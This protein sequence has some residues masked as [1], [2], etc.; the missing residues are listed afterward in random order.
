[1][2]K[3]MRCDRFR[4]LANTVG[5]VALTVNRASCDVLAWEVSWKEP[6][7]GLFDSPPGTQDLQEFR[8]EHNITILLPLTLLDPDDHALAVDGGRGECDGLGDAQAGGIA[9]GQDC[10]MF[11]GSDATHPF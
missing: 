9:G 1:M 2:S 8:R 5:L 7:L 11:P 6:V 10:A 3:R 4:N